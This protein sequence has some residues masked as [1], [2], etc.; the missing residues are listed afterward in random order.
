[1][2]TEM[3]TGALLSYQLIPG[4]A[5]AT[6]SGNPSADPNNILVRLRPGADSAAAF[7]TLQRLVPASNG[8]VV[9]PVQRPAEIVNYRSMG[10]TPALLGA[11]LGAGAVIA[12][13]LTLIASVRRRRRDLALFKTLGFTRR[14]LGSRRRLAVQHRRRRWDHRGRAP[15][16]RLGPLP[17]GSVRPADRRRTPTN[18][19][20][21]DGRPHR[22]GALRAL[23]NVVA[24]LPGRIAARTPTALLLRAE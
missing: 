2:H 10:T 3:G 6:G 14:Q 7:R 8:G 18:R 11:A 1:M 12:L 17:V 20:Q 21:L 4:D 23:A 19:P 13:G 22:L 9:A 15:R 24:A 5:A 16:D